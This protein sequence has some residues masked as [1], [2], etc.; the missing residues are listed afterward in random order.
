MWAENF[1]RVH[2]H[3]PGSFSP[4]SFNKM[5]A[6]S[7]NSNIDRSLI[8]KIFLLMKEGLMENFLEDTTYLAQSHDQE[9]KLDTLPWL[10]YEHFRCT[11]NA[12]KTSIPS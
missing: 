6:I 9:K 3:A 12:S 11:Q 7:G 8:L 5:M 4:F 2:T 1:T 10:I